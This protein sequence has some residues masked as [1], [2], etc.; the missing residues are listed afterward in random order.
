M[1]SDEDVVEAVANDLPKAHIMVSLVVPMQGLR[2]AEFQTGGEA[3]VV[4]ADAFALTS[5]WQI[6]RYLVEEWIACH[7]PPLSNE[8]Q[9]SEFERRDGYVYPILDVAPSD[10]FSIDFSF[11]NY[12]EHK[13]E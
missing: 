7:S 12:I 11:M 8:T 10:A 6:R 5:H 9:F 1:C 2:L 3:N 13:A 4:A